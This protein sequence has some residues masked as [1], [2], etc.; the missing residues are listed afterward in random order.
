MNYY[1]P[2]T[3]D[4][5]GAEMAIRCDFRVILEIM[6]MLQDDELD[7]AEKTLAL[8]QMFYVAPEEIRDAEKAVEACLN[9]IEGGKSAGN[10]KRPRLTDFEQDFE[11]IIAPVNRVLGFE[12]RAVEYD[13]EKNTGGVHWWTFLSAYMEIGGDCLY[14][15]IVS[16]R[17]KQ[18]RKAK[19]EKHEKQ[20]LRRNADIVRL[21]PRY[22]AA[23][24]A[25][26]EEWTKGG[27]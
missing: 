13:P 3:V 10:K 19:L 22:T 25:L 14:A 26:I 4:I 21:K 8:L 5:D 23:D 12:S 15:Q 11:Y 24:E 27:G 18:A 1:L 17:D 2:K 9:F 20:W 16:I 7:G 6:Q